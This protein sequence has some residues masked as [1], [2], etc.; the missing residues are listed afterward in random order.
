ML[1]QHEI[2][3][4]ASPAL[5]PLGVHRVADRLEAGGAQ[6]LERPLGAV[7]GGDVARVA[8]D[9]GDA[10]AAGR[11]QVLDREP[12]AGVVVG[13]QRDVGRV[14]GGRVRVDDRNRDVLAERRPR[15]GLPAH[16]D[17]AV[18]PPAEQRLEVVLLPDVVAARVAE[19]DVDLAR[20]ESVFGAHQDR[21]DEAAFEVAGE[22]ADGAGTAGHQALR[23]LVRREGD[24]GRRIDHALAGGGGDLVASVERLGRRRDRDAGERGDVAQGRRL[25]DGRRFSYVPRSPPCENVSGPRLLTPALP[26][27]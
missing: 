21:D 8:G 9:V 23:L 12:S 19:E 17:D 4:R 5:R 20:A 13:R 6:R 15:V 27:G 14:V 11:D 25:A 26:S 3:G 1:R 18:D 24:L 7:A 16:D 10:G 22:Q 2:G